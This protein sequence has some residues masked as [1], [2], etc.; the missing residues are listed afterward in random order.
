[1]SVIPDRG[2]EFSK[3]MPEADYYEGRPEGF[4]VYS[5]SPEPPGTRAV[6]CTQVHLHI[7]IAGGAIRFLVRF[8]GPDTLD[9][10]IAALQEHRADVW[11]KP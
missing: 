9:R 11:G 2:A 10:F 5:W 4:D 6:K 7:P 1:M 8:K 3:G